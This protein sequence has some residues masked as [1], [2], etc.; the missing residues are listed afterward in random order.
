MHLPSSICSWRKAPI[1]ASTLPHP[2]QVLFVHTSLSFWSISQV[3]SGAQ[4]TL[5]VPLVLGCSG[6]SATAAGPAG[7]EGP[8]E[9]PL[10]LETLAV[11]NSQCRCCLCLVSG[12]ESPPCAEIIMMDFCSG[13]IAC[14]C[15][16][17][18][19][20]QLSSSLSAAAV[21]EL[22]ISKS[23]MMHIPGR[24][25]IKYFIASDTET[26]PNLVSFSGGHI[27]S[28]CPALGESRACLGFRGCRA[29]HCW[30]QSPC[31]QGQPSC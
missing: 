10:P 11:L 3:S 4:R 12:T 23:V 29:G 16:W 18:N 19:V 2:K 1:K 9:P 20:C 13:V 22:Q 15:S 27:L 5:C 26:A 6:S 24:A 30:Q 28:D 14:V 7:A 8:A 31:S 17:V 21:T 25:G